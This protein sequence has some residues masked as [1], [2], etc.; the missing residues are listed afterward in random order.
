MK[1]FLVAVLF[2][3][4]TANAAERVI[5]NAM[6]PFLAADGRGGFVLSWFEPKVKAVRVATLRGDAWSE[7][8]TIA[9]GE[10]VKANRADTPVIAADGDT[11]VATYSVSKGGHGRN[12]YITRSADAGK[13]WSKP[14][15]P[16]PALASEFGFVSLTPHGDMI[17]LDGRGLPGGHEGAGDMQFHYTTLGKDGTLAKDETLDARVCDCCPTAMVLTPRGPLVAYRDRSDS[18]VRDISIVRRTDAGWTKP[19]TVHADGWT[20]KGCPV[21]G[22]QLDSRGNDV[23]IAWFTGANDDPRVN[24]A[25]SRDGGATFGKPV[26][27]D[28][29]R[30]AGRS[31]VAFLGDGAAVVTWIA[32]GAL[33]A[34]R[35]GRDG[36]LGKPV[37]I[38]EAAGLPRVAVSKENVAVAFGAGDGVRFAMIDLP[39]N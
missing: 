3:A 10:T 30:P 16:H 34:R 29:G 35:V 38:A 25:F 28:G 2:L 18:E 13:T 24:V 5:P 6:A 4:G 14:L 9:S 37:R 39:R 12:V 21:N 33:H 22:P 32:D 27:V 8:R 11:I 15:M 23:V 7:P 17:W 20:I 1:R 36:A 19:R 26:R 31:D